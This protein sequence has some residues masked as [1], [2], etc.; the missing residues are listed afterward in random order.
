MNDKQPNF[1]ERR[2]ALLKKIARE[3]TL[4]PREDWPRPILGDPQGL[5]EYKLGTDGKWVAMT[6]GRIYSM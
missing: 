5:T 1:Q 6:T 3:G 4:V 2:Q